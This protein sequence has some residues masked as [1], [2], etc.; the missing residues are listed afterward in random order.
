[1]DKVLPEFLNHLLT[2]ASQPGD[3]LPS[4]NEI[5]SALGISVGKLRE[6]LRRASPGLG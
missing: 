4:L 6:Q 3:R 2:E 1:M 5:S